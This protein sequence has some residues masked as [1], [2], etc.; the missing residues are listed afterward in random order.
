VENEPLPPSFHEEVEVSYHLRQRSFCSEEG[1]L[2]LLDECI[3]S[4]LDGSS[5]P[6]QHHTDGAVQPFYYFLLTQSVDTSVSFVRSS[7]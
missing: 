2:L 1:G 5:M 3:G 7:V 6:H 4:L